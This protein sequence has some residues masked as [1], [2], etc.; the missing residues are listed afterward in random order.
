MFIFRMLI[1]LHVYVIAIVCLTSHQIF[2]YV[3]PTDNRID[4]SLYNIGIGISDVT[5]PAAGVNMVSN[6]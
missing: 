6:D 5:G 3:D 4:P 2:G 1:K